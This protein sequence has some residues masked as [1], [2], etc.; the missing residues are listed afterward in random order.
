MESIK[1]AKL[2]S[3]RQIAREAMAST[4]SF[5]SGRTNSERMNERESYGEGANVA[6]QN[7]GEDLLS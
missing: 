1:D 2:S 4:M 7:S 3:W 5:A 6:S